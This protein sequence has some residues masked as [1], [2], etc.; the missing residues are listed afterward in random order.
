MAEEKETPEYSQKWWVSVL[1]KREKEMDKEWRL[2]GDTAVKRYLDERPESAQPE[3]D[4]KA[5]KYNIFWAN[6][7]IVKSALYAN[8]PKPSIKR[9]H[10]DAKDD[11]ARTAALILQRM[12]E[13]DLQKDDSETHESL[14]NA[15]DDYL[16]PGLGQIWLRYDVETEKYQI[17]E[18]VDPLTGAVIPATEAEKIVHEEI[19]TDYVHW[20]DFFYSPCRT[21]KENWWVGRRVWMRKGKAE[22]KFGAEKIKAIVD[23]VKTMEEEGKDMPKGFTDGKV[24]IF[25][26][27]CE[28][29]NKV[30]FVNRHAD[31]LLDSKDDPLG[32]DEFFPCPKPLIT[33]H[34]TSK[35]Q[36]RSDYEM[37]RDQYEQL[38]T[39]NQRIDMLTRA[40]RIVGVY[41]GTNA[42]LKTLL[43]GN[44]M[45]MVPVDNWAAFGETG[46]LKGSV[47]WFP[48]EVI[49]AVLEKLMM[50]RTAV[51]GQIY[52][53]TSISD[54]M[55]GA[56]NPRDTLGAQK[57]KAQYSSVRLQL[58]QQ[59]VA[60][61]V[62]SVLRLKCEIICRLFQP[63]TIIEQ[64]Q[65]LLTESAALA[66]PAIELLKSYTASQYKIEISEETLSIADYNA[67][68]QLRVEYL[69]AVGQFIS[70]AGTIL[71]Q[72]PEATPFLLQM[73]QWVTAS[74]RGSSD[75]ESVLDNAIK[76]ATAA[77]PKPNGE[78]PDMTGVMENKSRAEA[79]TASARAKAE[80]QIAVQNNKT[81]NAAKEAIIK[82]AEA[83]AMPQEPPNADV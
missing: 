45:R 10:D 76:A 54:I 22:K 20:R 23:N 67:E 71:E 26:L 40:L 17:P 31:E 13:F 24:E 63:Q 73:I 15:V 12:M 57:L 28:E 48:V 70:Q 30:Y 47:D 55:R 78:P 59:D 46:G 14:D 7:Q 32:L 39:L 62:R 33:T 53:L 6:T 82:V 3:T 2:D 35:F 5:R 11:V 64:S 61:F 37:V 65:I 44:E 36:P 8:P 34:S 18:Q 1:E 74:F 68:R 51:V 50:Q 42:E 49:A 66:G 60:K 81:Q 41:D 43:S 72:R 56:S 38:D 75:I 69:S 58:K 27:W 25:E 80:S 79:D 9:Q 19:C 16:L 83:N 52:E 4:P 21:W 77:P 29:T